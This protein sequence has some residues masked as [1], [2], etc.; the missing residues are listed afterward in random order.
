MSFCPLVLADFDPIS[1]RTDEI[2]DQF[3]DL[4]AS[5]T[6]P[7]WGSDVVLEGISRA[8]ILGE[9]RVTLQ[10]LC[11]CSPSMSLGPGVEAHVAVSARPAVL[12]WLEAHLDAKP[13][14]DSM[15]A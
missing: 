12:S 15:Y 10:V 2:G 5:F 13:Y 14:S 8:R 4:S 1:V 9:K 11:R 7:G 6:R 3:I